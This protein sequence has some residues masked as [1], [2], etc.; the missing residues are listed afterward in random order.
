VCSSDLQND[1]GIMGSLPARVDRELLASWAERVPPPQDE[2]VRQLVAVL[3]PGRSS[4]V[5][6]ATK[7]ALAAA[8]R[9][10]YRA[11]PAALELQAAGAIIPPTVDNHR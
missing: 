7:R 8:V 3:P 6:A 10:H 11:H 9:A 4:S 5:D 2:L 1:E